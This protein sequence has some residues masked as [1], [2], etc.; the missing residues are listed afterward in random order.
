VSH[1]WQEWFQFI[2]GG[3]VQIWLGVSLI[4][5][6]W[7]REQRRRYLDAQNK[8]W[9]SIVRDALAKRQGDSR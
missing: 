1:T 9:E 5:W 8:K 2:G 7:R 6:G 3:A 4:L